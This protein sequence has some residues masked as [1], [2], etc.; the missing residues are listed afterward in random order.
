[1]SVNVLQ[2]T[3]FLRYFMFMLD[4]CAGG[5]LFGV[6][7]ESVEILEKVLKESKRISSNINRFILSFIF[8][9]FI[10]YYIND[11]FISRLSTP[12]NQ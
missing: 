7:T 2:A 5:R 12:G 8:I 11:C 9:I 3:P 10:N 6:E 1:M 4:W